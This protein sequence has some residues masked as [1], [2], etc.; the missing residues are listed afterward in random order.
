MRSNKM[1][2]NHFAI[3]RTE[4]ETRVVYAPFNM[5]WR[6]FRGTTTLQIHSKVALRSSSGGWD[7]PKTKTQE[8][9]SV[10]SI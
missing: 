4:T 1:F 9:L 10:Y 3:D 6:W 8:R 7:L 2:N 5:K